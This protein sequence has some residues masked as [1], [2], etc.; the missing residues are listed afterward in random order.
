MRRCVVKVANVN[1]VVFGLPNKIL[2]QLNLPFG[3]RAKQKEKIAFAYDKYIFLKLWQ[4][5]HF[6]TYNSHNNS[7]NN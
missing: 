3:K 2:N 5:G 7:N 1:K 6:Y 4:D